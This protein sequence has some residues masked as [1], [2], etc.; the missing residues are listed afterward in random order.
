LRC[1]YADFEAAL[2]DGWKGLWGY[3]ETHA[4]AVNVPA[5]AIPDAAYCF[6]MNL[7]SICRFDSK[8]VAMMRK[9]LQIIHDLKQSSI[10]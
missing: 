10:L 8:A 5:A 7:A 4:S 9:E 1:K 6:L 2:E 3:G